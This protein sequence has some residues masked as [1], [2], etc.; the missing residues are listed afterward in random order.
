[1]DRPTDTPTDGDTEEE[2]EEDKDKD[3]DD[4]DDL[5]QR[6]HGLVCCCVGPDVTHAGVIQHSGSGAD[7]PHRFQ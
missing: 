5:A 4:D 1:M 2:E 3:D 7:F 6:L